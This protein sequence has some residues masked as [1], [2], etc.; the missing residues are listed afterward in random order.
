MLGYAPW[1]TP[2]LRQ[3]TP[4]SRH[5]PGTADKIQV[6]RLP[7]APEMPRTPHR[8]GNE[9]WLASTLSLY[10]INVKGLNSPQKRVRALRELRALHISIAFFQETHFKTRNH[11]QFSSKYYPLGFHA[12][13]LE[14]KTKGTS[15]LFS[16]DTPF[17]KE[18]EIADPEGRYL[19]LKGTIH[20][21]HFTL[22]NVYLPNKGQKPFPNK[23]LAALEPFSEGILTLGGDLNAPLDQRLDTSRGTSNFPEHVLRGMRENL[24]KFQLPT[25][26]IEDQLEHFFLTNTPRDSTPET[27]WEAHKCAIR[28]TLIH[29]G[30]QRKKQRAKAIMDLLQKVAELETR[31]KTTLDED[32]Y[33]ELVEA[34]AALNLHLSHKIEFQLRMAQKTYYE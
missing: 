6:D 33:T 2:L 14:S 28:G 20:Q 26:Q 1:R 25:A 17:R 10:L 24:H 13:N 27:I 34:R 16:S 4:L 11:Q 31:H 7:P 30:A 21:T 8:T 5:H 23:I 32:A 18:A 3:T 19:F 15:I 29:Q 9:P 12:T 22:A